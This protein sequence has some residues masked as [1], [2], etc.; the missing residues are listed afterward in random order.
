MHIKPLFIPLFSADNDVLIDDEMA[1]N[2]LTYLENQP[3]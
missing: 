3:I 1:A 2:Q